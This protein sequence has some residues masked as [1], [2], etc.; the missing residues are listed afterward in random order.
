[1]I[2]YVG[3]MLSRHG[4]SVNFI[5]LLVPK[6]GAYYEVKAASSKKNKVVRLL[7]MVYCILANRRRCKAVLIDTYST[8]AFLYA[9]IASRLCRILS[10]PYVPVLHG[11]NLPDRFQ[12]DKQKVG[13]FLKGAHSIISPS[14]YLQ[15]FFSGKGFRV[16]FIPNF[17]ELQKYTFLPR[18]PVRPRLLWVRAF[19]EIYNPILA[20]QALKILLTRYPSAQLCMVGAAKDHTFDDVMK[21]ITD[22]GLS[23]HIEITGIL[24]KSEWIRRSQHYDVFINTTTIDNM[25]ISVIEAMALGLPVVSTNV[26]GIPYL[27]HH[28]Q[29]GILVPS[30][31]AEDMAEAIRELVENPVKASMLAQQARTKVEGFSWDQV[32]TKWLERIDSI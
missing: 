29:D 7:D 9:Y 26:G 23:D 2:V 10:L 14:L 22:Y 28:D 13:T 18:Y 15:D 25:P 31:S 19:Q 11:G 5:E 24:P 27:I 32:K 4:S 17:I 3:N 1:M 21:A 8:S 30:G 20:I 12:R 6:L 16:Y